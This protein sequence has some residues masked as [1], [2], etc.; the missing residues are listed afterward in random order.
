MSPSLEELVVK[1]IQMQW[2]DFCP[3]YWTSLGGDFKVR[4]KI[5]THIM[6]YHAM[7]YEIETTKNCPK[8]KYSFEFTMAVNFISLIALSIKKIDQK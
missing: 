2:N 6:P 3:K 4:I 7:H 1:L 5:T 8:Q